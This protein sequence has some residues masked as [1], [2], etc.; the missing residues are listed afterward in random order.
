MQFDFQLHM[1]QSQIG[2]GANS[3]PAD[4][5]QWHQ[6]Q[7]IPGQYTLQE[8][9]C[10]ASAPHSAI[11]FGKSATWPALAFSISQGTKVVMLNVLMK[12]L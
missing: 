11:P 9:K 8:Q 3:N 6:W 10:K 2:S 7:R 1:Q 4:Q 12:I 5:Y